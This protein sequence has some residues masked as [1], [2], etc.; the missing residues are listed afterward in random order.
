MRSLVALTAAAALLT[1]CSDE[2]GT[3]RVLLAAGYTQ[4]Q[5]GGHA[6]WG[7]A[8]DDTFQTAF[9]ATGPT[10]KPVQGVA[11]AGWLT[12]STTHLE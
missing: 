2:A 6:P 9:R 11:W 12:G 7:C 10:G 5:V 8:D 1:A 4:I 3:H